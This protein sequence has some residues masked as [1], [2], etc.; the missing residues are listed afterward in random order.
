MFRYWAN[1]T[2]CDF[3]NL[4]RLSRKAK[5]KKDVTQRISI[6]W[7]DVIVHKNCAVPSDYAQLDTKKYWRKLGYFWEVKKKIL[8]ATKSFSDLFQYLWKHMVNVILRY[9]NATSFFDIINILKNIQKKILDIEIEI[10]HR[11]LTIFS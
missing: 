2:I 11:N 9:K 5:G 6:F 3:K 8:S 1:P 4:I 10:Q 7:S